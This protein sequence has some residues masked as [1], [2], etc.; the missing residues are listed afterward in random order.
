MRA[1]IW[2][3]WT[4]LIASLGLKAIVPPGPALPTTNPAAAASSTKS[5]G[6]ATGAPLE[7]RSGRTSEK[8]GRPA[9]STVSVCRPPTRVAT[10]ATCARVMVSVGPK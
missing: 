6:Y 1:S 5:K 2:A 8:L 4:L 7:S 9:F 10:L 3:S